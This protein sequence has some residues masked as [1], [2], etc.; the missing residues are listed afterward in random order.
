MQNSRRKLRGS[1]P[2]T[3]KTSWRSGFTLIELL[4]VISIIALL[5]AILLPALAKARELANRAVCSVNVRSLIQS[6][7]IYAQDNSQMFP[8]AQAPASTTYENG[9]NM[10]AA[11]TSVTADAAGQQA[12]A[13]GPMTSSPLASMWLL[14]LNG[15]MTAKSFICPSDPYA[16]QPSELYNA[17]SQYF[18][19][20]GMVN[21]TTSGIGVGESYSI[22][23]PWNG[24]NGAIGAWWTNTTTADL[25]LAADMAPANDTAGGG[26]MARDPLLGLNNS[27]GNY[28]FNSGNHAGDGQNVGYG[29]DHVVWKDN[30]YVGEGSDSIYSYDNSAV[31]TDGAASCGSTGSAAVFAAWST[32]APASYDVWMAP[33]RD[34]ENGNW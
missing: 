11:D 8:A 16:T 23:F 2:A 1:V 13:S 24:T 7:I 9:A 20:F 15:Q 21:N 14:A 19:N 4:V 17:S 25:P 30:P 31:A 22:D 29:D 26:P 3:S 34:V 18:D 6:M 33:V 27:D 12:F 32:G 10:T 5:I 28:I